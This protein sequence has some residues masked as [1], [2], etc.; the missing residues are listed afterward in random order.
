MCVCVCVCVCICVC[1]GEREEREGREGEHREA[2]TG[3]ALLLG[4]CAERGARS[5]TGE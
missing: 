4:V 3:C 2:A 1:E 5:R